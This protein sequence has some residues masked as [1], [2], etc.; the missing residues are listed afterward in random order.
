MLTSV[1]TTVLKEYNIEIISEVDTETLRMIYIELSVNEKKHQVI[2]INPS[3]YTVV[4]Q[5]RVPSTTTIYTTHDQ[6]N[7]GST[8]TQISTTSTLGNLNIGTSVHGTTRGL[9][10]TTLTTTEKTKASTFVIFSSVPII[11]GVS[12]N[13]QGKCSLF[14][15]LFVIIALI[16]GILIGVVIGCAFCYVQ[17]RIRKPKEIQFL[18]LNNKGHE[19]ITNDLSKATFVVKDKRDI[20]GD[21]NE[22]DSLF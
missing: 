11:S 13:D 2:N 9:T 7:K 6:D 12:T 19:D 4:L 8:A 20:D 5:G 15:I 10:V 1:H 18:M 17:R 3:N 21:E 22:D 14:V 16:I